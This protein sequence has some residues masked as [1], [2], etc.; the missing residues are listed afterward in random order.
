MIKYLTYNE[1]DKT[2]W[3]DCISNAFNG[4][5]YAY[6]WYL[7]I[8]C[9]SW[10]ALVEDDYERVFPLTNG[11]KSGINYLFQPF[12][13]QQLGV[14]SKSKLNEKN[15]ENFIENI[16]HKYK[17]AEINLNTFNKISDEKYHLIPNLTHELDLI[18]PYEATYNH[19][20]ENTKR[21][22]RLAIN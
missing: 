1:I 4:I 15:I 18:P 2:R 13:T 5:I 10:D 16:P 22:I 6:S 11:K 9:P 3:D 12:F 19:Y 8:V 17:F 21:N 14:F 7:D 20:S